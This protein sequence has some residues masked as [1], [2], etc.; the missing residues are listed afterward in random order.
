MH[1]LKQLVIKRPENCLLTRLG[2]KR[3]RILPRVRVGIVHLDVVVVGVIVPVPA[4][5]AIPSP[6]SASGVVD[7]SISVVVIIVVVIVV[8]IIKPKVKLEDL[9]QPLERVTFCITW[10]RPFVRRSMVWEAHHSFA[11]D[12]S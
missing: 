10:D 1:Q 11:S 7:L 12:I 5:V 6:P 2:M 9:K 8:V 4:P 3:L